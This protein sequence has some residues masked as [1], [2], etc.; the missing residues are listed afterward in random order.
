[1]AVAVAVLAVVNAIKNLAVE[2]VNYADQVG[3]LAQKWGFT[4]DQIQEFDYWATMNGTTLESLMT[5]M[6]GLVNQAEAGAGAFDKLGISVMTTDGK[7]KDQKT[8]FMETLDAL[9]KVENQTERNALQ[10]EI[11]GRAGIE[12]GQIINMTSEELDKLSQT[13]H[14]YGL[15]IDE[16]TIEKSG[17]FNDALDTLKKQFTSV[18][19]SML[20]GSEDADKKFEAFMANLE[21]GIE[22]YLPKF[23]AFIIKLIP[24][25]IYAIIDALPSIIESLFDAI[26]DLDWIS[27]GLEA[28]K[29]LVKG[30]AMAIWE[31]LQ[32]LVGKGWI[33]GKKDKS[34]DISTYSAD[35]A[36]STITNSKISEKTTT[37]NETLDVTLKVE[38][39]GTVAGQE[40]LNIM[41]DLLVDKINKA[42]GDEID[43]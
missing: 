27:L 14:D 36:I 3:D 30:L 20:S 43:G 35:D 37:V 17:K 42:L 12:M 40:N 7:L 11:F 32:I 6:R 23:I 33:W 28:G 15:I 26:L 1:M 31:G 4:T 10:F 18:V 24:R 21:N 34:V 39:D 19:A 38:S 13:A 29:S 2:T 9:N 5:G 22:Q 25:A 8:L 41:S 16:E